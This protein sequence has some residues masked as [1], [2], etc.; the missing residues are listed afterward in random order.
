MAENGNNNDGGNGGDPMS[1]PPG[2]SFAEMTVKELCVRARACLATL[3]ATIDELESRLV[4]NEEDEE[5]Q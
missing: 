1:P 2:P 4:E 5:D 3:E